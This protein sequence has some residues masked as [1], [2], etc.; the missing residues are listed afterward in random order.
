MEQFLDVEIK[1]FRILE[2]KIERLIARMT[3]IKKERDLALK[4]KSE[5]EVVLR[6][7]E[8]ENAQLKDRVQNA[9]QRA[10][11]PKKSEEIRSRLSGL[12]EKLDDLDKF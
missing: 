2:E 4:Q 5:I 7:R 8:T 10:L 11:D 1:N 3:E 12:I 9:E 6:R